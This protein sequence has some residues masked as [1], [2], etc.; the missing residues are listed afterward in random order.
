MDAISRRYFARPMRSNIVPE[1]S[2][3]PGKRERY[4]FFFLLFGDWSTHDF[5]VM[6]I[7]H[8]NCS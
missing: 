7:F 3:A 6:A 1:I 8:Q 5:E 2:L 4:K